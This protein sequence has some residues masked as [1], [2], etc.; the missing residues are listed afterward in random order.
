MQGFV[1]LDGIRIMNVDVECTEQLKLLLTVLPRARDEVG[2]S[3]K[4]LFRFIAPWTIA[5]KA[6][7]KQTVEKSFFMHGSV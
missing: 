3:K 7:H 4:L 5:V 1:G 2:N 6:L